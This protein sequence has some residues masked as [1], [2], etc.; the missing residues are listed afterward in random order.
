MN[1]LK[2]IPF[3]LFLLVL[4]FCLHG[5]VENYGY[6]NPGEVV[7]VGTEILFCLALCFLLLFFLT[8]KNYIIS[9]LIL[10]FIATWYL[11]FGAIQDWIKSTSFLSFLLHYAVLLPVLLIC[12]I[13]WIVFLKRK[14]SIQNKLVLYFNILM[15][16][17]CCI[18]VYG[19]LHKRMVVEKKQPMAS[20]AFDSTKVRS[21]PNVYYLLF[22]EYPGYKS[23]K[24]SFGYAN[25]SLYHFFEQNEF[26]ILPVFSNYNVTNFSMSSILNMR[27]VDGHYDPQHLDQHDF[28]L[29]LDEIRTA[30][31]VA[32]F[33]LMG[34]QFRNCSIFDVDDQHGV[35]DHNSFLPVH[36]LLLTDKI[37]HNRLI[38][39]TGSWL[40]KFP[41]WK[42]KYL[43]QHD[44]NNKISED[45]VRKIAA[46]KKDAP[47]FCYA[48]FLMPHPPF[49]R[50]STGEYYS[51]EQLNDQ[52]DRKKELY[53]SYVKYTNSFIHSLV[54]RLVSDD[55][56]AIL[57]VMSD[58][59]YRDFKDMAPNVPF[60]FDNI[61][62]VRFPDKDYIA[63]KE[64]WSSVNF[65]RYLFNCEFGQHIPY[66]AD[67]SIMLNY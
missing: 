7:M 43:F 30:S 17:Y 31:V 65:F 16:I 14:R 28:Q 4:F 35:D 47:L 25:D 42:R 60:N 29:R 37:F 18:D 12:T 26:K 32:V 66:L 5:S 51:E 13:G 11:F 58:H 62:A 67:S 54:N 9:S 21:K 59:G 36:S 33:K 53:L 34:Y 15:L 23:L 19:L 24:D 48:H 52:H 49:Y 45:M 57:V 1:A 55:P 6:V 63:M 44:V 46:E 40:V 8:R 39:A 22:D 64:K 56:N 38:R 61:C 50:D 20:I 27:Y 2:K 3:F 41:A 10:F